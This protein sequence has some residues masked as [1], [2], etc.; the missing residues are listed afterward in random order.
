[1]AHSWHQLR[2][3]LIWFFSAELQQ[4]AWLRVAGDG[5]SHHVTCMREGLA[6]VQRVTACVG[7]QQSHCTQEAPESLI[8]LRII[9]P[10]RKVNKEK[11]LSIFS[12]FLMLFMQI[13]VKC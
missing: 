8:L 9:D 13:F 10:V 11:D 6:Y 4:V 3:L 7:A 5:N 2:H 12:L 1:M